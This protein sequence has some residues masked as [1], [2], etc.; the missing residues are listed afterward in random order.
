MNKH[1]LTSLFSPR[2]VLIFSGSQHHP[3]RQSP[4]AKVFMQ[5]FQNNAF[6]GT[7]TYLDIHMKG[8]LGDLAQ[9]RADL[10]VIALPN[11]Q[12]EAAMEVVG[13]IQ[14]RSALIL[15]MG[16]DAALAKRRPGSGGV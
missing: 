16:V 15:S 4:M 1:Y 11:E 9:S 5:H 7:V 14:C 13:R 6:E 10:A 8:T 12:L 2:S 3:E